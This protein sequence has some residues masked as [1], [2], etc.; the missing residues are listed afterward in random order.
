MNENRF[1]I[2]L[3]A[4]RLRPE[5]DKTSFSPDNISRKL[6]FSNETKILKKIHGIDAVS[7]QPTKTFDGI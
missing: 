6:I 5:S 3:S 1:P 7:H 2:S 4:Q